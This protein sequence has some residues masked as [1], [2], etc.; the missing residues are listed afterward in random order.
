M[1]YFLSLIEEKSRRDFSNS[2]PFIRVYPSD[3]C[4]LPTILDEL[5]GAALDY[6]RARGE[7]PSQVAVFRDCYPEEDG[8]QI[9]YNIYS[10]YGDHFV[11]AE[12]LKVTE[13]TEDVAL[14]PLPESTGRFGPVFHGDW[15]VIYHGIHYRDDFLTMYEQFLRG[16]DPSILPDAPT[17]D[18]KFGNQPSVMEDRSGKTT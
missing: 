17:H 10:M 16:V 4:D 9:L 15:N 13:P 12:L 2:Y 6:A 8:Q 14:D 7:I 3:E 1:T 11:S 5:Y 18:V